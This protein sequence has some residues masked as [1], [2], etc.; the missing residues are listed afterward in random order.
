MS[1]HQC[2]DTSYRCRED[3]NRGRTR[4]VYEEAGIYICPTCDGTGHAY[5]GAG[6]QTCHSTG[7]VLAKKYPKGKDGGR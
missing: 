7:R 2:H 3:D 1:K 6:C 4:C 5:I